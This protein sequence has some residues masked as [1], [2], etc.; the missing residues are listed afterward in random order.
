M[1]V[2]TLL[3]KILH[4]E[5]VTSGQRKYITTKTDNHTHSTPK[6]VRAELKDNITYNIHNYRY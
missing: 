2:H 4:K 1:Y 5:I 6:V 3:D